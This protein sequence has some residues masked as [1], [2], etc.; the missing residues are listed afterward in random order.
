MNEYRVIWEID[1]EAETPREAAQ[2]ALDIQRN[3]DSIATCFT[4]RS[5]SIVNGKPAYKDEIIDF[6]E[7]SFEP[8]G[9]NPKDFKPGDIIQDIF[10]G[11]PYEVMEPDKRGMAT[12]KDAVGVLTHLNA[13]NNP[14]FR[15]AKENVCAQ[16]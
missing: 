5:A 13:Y 4:V 12:L 3:P 7:D 8:D 10:T 14:R 1:I 15:I 16:E 9:D 6:D 11:E 2:Q